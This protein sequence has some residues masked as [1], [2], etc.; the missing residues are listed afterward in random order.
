MQRATPTGTIYPGLL[1]LGSERAPLSW[2]SKCGDVS[3]GSFVINL[4]YLNFEIF[5]VPRRRPK[6]QEVTLTGVIYGAQT[7]H[8]PQ[9]LPGGQRGKVVNALLA[10]VLN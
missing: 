8:V 7:T 5:V 1:S 4:L 2:G 6:A 9:T 10:A 3:C